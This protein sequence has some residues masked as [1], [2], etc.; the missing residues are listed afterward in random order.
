MIHNQQKLNRA[1]A[2]R[3]LRIEPD[4]LDQYTTNW[5]MKHYRQSKRKL[6]TKKELQRF[7]NLPGNH[8]QV[9]YDQYGLIRPKKHGIVIELYPDGIT[10]FGQKPQKSTVR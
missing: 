5:G 6:F 8:E 4:K 2:A 10:G 7:A 3:Y 1:E 9:E